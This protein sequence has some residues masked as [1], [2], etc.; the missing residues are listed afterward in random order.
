MLLNPLIYSRFL[1]CYFSIK[2]GGI[3]PMQKLVGLVRRCV[4][5]YH[6]IES[7]DKSAGGVCG[8]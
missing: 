4:E 8:G 3:V 5:D 6:M 2:I 7:G 1:V